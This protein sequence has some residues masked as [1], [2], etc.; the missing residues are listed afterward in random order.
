MTHLPDG[1]KHTHR[2]TYDIAVEGADAFFPEIDRDV[3][4]G[5]SIYQQTLA[6]ADR[7]YLSRIKALERIEKDTG[8]EQEVMIIGRE[9]H[10]DMRLVTF[11]TS[12]DLAIPL[13]NR[14]NLIVTRNP[15]GYISGITTGKNVIMGSKTWESLGCRI[16]KNNE[17]PWRLP[18]DLANFKA[19]P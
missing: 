14:G 4:H 12:I 9:E 16:G 2:W 3:F 13:P 11:H 7:I 8:K 17:L 15:E 10:T 6:R 19:S 5:A 1:Q 18:A